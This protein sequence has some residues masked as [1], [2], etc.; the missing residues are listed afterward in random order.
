MRNVLTRKNIIVM[1]QYIKY[2]CAFLT[3]IGMSVQAWSATGAISVTSEIILP[4][5]NTTNYTSGDWTGA[6]APSYSTSNDDVNNITIGG[7][8]VGSVRFYHAGGSGWLQLQSGNGYIETVIS[9]T[10]GVDV[11][12][13]MKSNGASGTITA[14]LTG[15]TS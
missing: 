1:K 9:S 3:F 12:V 4:K 7:N 13:Y 8:V 15:A 5:G 14:A 6:G 10:Q 2:F 11:V